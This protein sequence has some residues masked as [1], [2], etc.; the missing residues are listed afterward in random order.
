MANVNIQKVNFQPQQK[1]TQTTL[2]AATKPAPTQ[3]DFTGRTEKGE[4]I[5]AWERIT[6]RHRAYYH[7]VIKRKDGVT[8][9]FN[10]FINDRAKVKPSQDVAASP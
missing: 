1:Q 5:A 10:L 6:K 4:R 8:E 2:G 9:A 7:V 3:P